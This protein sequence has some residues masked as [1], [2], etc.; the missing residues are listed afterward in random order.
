M[1][2]DEQTTWTEGDLPAAIEVKTKQNPW[3]IF[4]Y[5]RPKLLA[6]KV[7]RVENAS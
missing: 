5:Y 1:K 3:R 7:L 2:Q 4:Q 6:L